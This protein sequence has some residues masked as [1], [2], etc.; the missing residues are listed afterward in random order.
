ME[1]LAARVSQCRQCALNSSRTNTVFGA[2]D[3]GAGVVFVGEAP[4][5]EEDLSGIPFVGR[6]GK[7][8]D[9]ILEAIDFTR[10]QIYIANILKCRPPN[11]RDPL[12]NEVAACEPYLQRQLELMQPELICALGRVAAQ[13]LLRTKSSLGKMRQKLHYY[14]GIKLIATYHPAALLRNPNFKRPAWEDMKML[15]AI[16]ESSRE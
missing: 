16:Y 7:L 2:G 14:N 1:T 11:N 3:P 5:R 9:K 8:L 10:D 13:T 12:E 4:G 15:R 6:A